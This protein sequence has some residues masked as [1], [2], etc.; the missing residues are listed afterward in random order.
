METVD[1]KHKRAWNQ[2][3]QVALLGQLGLLPGL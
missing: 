2:Y 1:G 3:D